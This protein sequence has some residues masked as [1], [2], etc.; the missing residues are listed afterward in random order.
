[1]ECKEEAVGVICA[2]G[3]THKGI[4]GDHSGHVLVRKREMLEH[5]H[6]A[7]CELTE[8]RCCSVNDPLLNVHVLWHHNYGDDDSS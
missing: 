2:N 8:G 3:S 6:V 4:W 1:M 5:V 7:T